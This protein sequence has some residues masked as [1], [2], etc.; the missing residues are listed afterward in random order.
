VC[1]RFVRSASLGPRSGL[2]RSIPARKAPS[3]TCAT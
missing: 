2:L 1:H 3:K